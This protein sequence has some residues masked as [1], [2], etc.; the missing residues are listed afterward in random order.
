MK[1]EINLN[2]SD[3]D[4][5]CQFY[6]AVMT[7]NQSDRLDRIEATLERVA[8]QQEVNTAGIAELRNAIG[9]LV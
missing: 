7:T 1:Q 6:V 9:T 5:L 4:V 8:T 2:M 3:S